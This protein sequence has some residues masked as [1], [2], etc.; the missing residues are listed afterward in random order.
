LNCLNTPYADGG[1]SWCLDV[2]GSA[3][4]S[5]NLYVNGVTDLI[6]QTNA[7]SILPWSNNLYNLGSAGDQWANI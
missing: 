5:S 4:L 2:A 6:G 7:H 3:Y 1:T